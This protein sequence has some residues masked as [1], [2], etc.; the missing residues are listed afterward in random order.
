MRTLLSLQA[1]AGGCGSEPCP[2]SSLN[3]SIHTCRSSSW[4]KDIANLRWL[5]E[6]SNALCILYELRSRSRNWY[7]H[8][9]ERRVS[10]RGNTA[11]IVAT[12]II[13]QVK[14]DTLAYDPG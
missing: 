1:E 11:I 5:K 6:I 12:T 3:Q 14:S 13:C 7:L 9:A 4:E 10:S 2:V 8:K